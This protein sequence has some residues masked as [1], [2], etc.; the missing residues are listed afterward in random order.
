MKS[1]GT[2]PAAAQDLYTSPLF[3]GRRRWV[4]RTCPRWLILSAKYRLAT[5]KRVIAP[6]DQTLTGM[7]FAKRRELP[8]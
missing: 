7:P 2:R 6:Y 3:A 5:P 8:R 1:T 4:E